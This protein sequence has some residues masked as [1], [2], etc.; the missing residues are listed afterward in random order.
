MN[1]NEF[2]E[3]LKEKLS[4]LNT[5]DREDAINYYW[6]YFEEAGFGEESDVTKNVGDPADVAAKI[7]EAAECVKEHIDD[8]IAN[9]NI[10]AESAVNIQNEDVPVN[11]DMY[12]NTITALE[13]FGN[14]KLDVFDSI[15]LELSALNV[16]I[17][18]GDEFG[19]YLNCK[20]EPVIER[21]GDCLVIKDMRKQGFI[22]FNFNS[23]I[24]NKGREFIEVIVPRDK[25]L[26]RIKSSME[27]GKLSLFATKSDI[28]DLNADIGALEIVGVSTLNGSLSADKGHISVKDS[29]FEKLDV[30][31]DTGAV[32]L[33]YIKTKFLKASTDM[34]YISIENL[35][36]E[37]ADLSS[38][39]GYIKLTDIETDRLAASTDTGLIKLNRINSGYIEASSDTGSINA[40]LRGTQDDYSLDLSNDLGTIIIDGK[41]SGGSIFNSRYMENRGN[42]KVKMSVD[43][44][45]IN[46]DFLGR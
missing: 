31:N 27:F 40:N 8:D 24:F 1:K 29:S 32:N 34:G 13:I 6:E 17:R 2:M 20:D 23:N 11:Y 41:N 43:T 5:E 36:A 35:E 7:I 3:S 25:K 19:I 26:K 12:T 46:I 28:L 15:H 14:D 21:V 18:T 22:R 37:N 39:T 10:K 30:S 4:K 9:E 42:K 33:S 44:G 38:D 45:K 16:I